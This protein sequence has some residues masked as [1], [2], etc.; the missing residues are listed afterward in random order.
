MTS[1]LETSIEL[2]M[3]QLNLLKNPGVAGIGGTTSEGN[4]GEKS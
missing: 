1:D 2:R 4:L 3:H